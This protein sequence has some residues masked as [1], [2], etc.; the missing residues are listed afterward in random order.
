MG[1]DG[2]VSALVL[3]VPELEP[4]PMVGCCICS[5]ASRQRES[6]RVLGSVVTVRH[7]DDVIRQHPHRRYTDREG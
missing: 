5:A 1:E 4:V 2:S 3:R 7:C 6:A